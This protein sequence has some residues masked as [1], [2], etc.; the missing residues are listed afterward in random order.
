MLKNTKVLVL[1]GGGPRLFLLTYIECRYI[2]AV[3]ISIYDISIA[4][5]LEEKKGEQYV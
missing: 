1:H 2:I 3:D 4:D 5:I